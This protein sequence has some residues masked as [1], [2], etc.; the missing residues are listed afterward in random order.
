ML[1]GR[2]TLN[3][4]GESVRITVVLVVLAA[5]TLFLRVAQLRGTHVSAGSPATSIQ[6]RNLPIL[7]SFEAPAFGSAPAAQFSGVVLAAGSPCPG[8]RVTLVSDSHQLI[9]LTTDA[10][11]GFSWPFGSEAHQEV[12]WATVTDPVEHQVFTGAVPA[13]TNMVISIPDEHDYHGMLD[14]TFA[15]EGLLEHFAVQVYTDP[16][17]FGGEALLCGFGYPAPGGTIHIRIKETGCASL[18]LLGTYD[19]QPCLVRRIANST[20]L[21]DIEL[22]AQLSEVR[23]SISSD[24][25]PAFG[26][27]IRLAPQ[28]LPSFLMPASGL[29]DAKG[30]ARFI[31]EKGRAEYCVG[32]A[33][34]EPEWGFTDVDANA[35]HSVDVRLTKS[36]EQPT[37][38]GRVV[39]GLSRAASGSAVSLLPTTRHPEL[40]VA[41]IMTITA[42]DTGRYAFCA[43]PGRAYSLVASHPAYGVTSEVVVMPG[44]DEHLLAFSEQ[45]GI[46]VDVSHVFCDYA[47]APAG[48]VA[49]VISDRLLERDIAGTSGLPLRYFGLAPGEYNVYVRLPGGHSYGCASVSVK[50]NIVS[51][52]KI[53]LSPGQWL[54]GRIGPDN[55]PQ[56]ADTWVEVL[57]PQWP[58]QVTQI[59]G[60]AQVAPDGVFRVFAGD[61]THGII[62][63]IQRDAVMALSSASTDQDNVID[64][65]LFSKQ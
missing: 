5:L 19:N 46:A 54:S 59:W 24:I 31:L 4:K 2:R 21:E 25:G 7:H 14:V 9:S 65:G 40:A 3:T 37:I 36:P 28:G 30:R 35:Q 61:L 43:T 11:G 55:S 39:N 20:F 38:V 45:G 29:A 8:H 1:P 23:Y 33:P 48:R 64:L 16:N 27:E 58:A 62:R 60:R 51:D 15:N 34:Y 26:A 22:Q 44:V 13:S 47:P 6:S 53:V 12:F 63:V 42:E 32:L 17:S 57:H 50:P 56:L 52:V 49:F 10:N 41:G 18:L